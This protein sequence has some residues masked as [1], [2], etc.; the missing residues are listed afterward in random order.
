MLEGA[1]R[2]AAEH[3]CRVAHFWNLMWLN[4]KPLLQHNA[5]CL[6]GRGTTEK[7]AWLHAHAYGE[8]M[9]WRIPVGHPACRDWVNMRTEQLISYEAKR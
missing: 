7:K 9:A 4:C 6:R 3:R 5:Q 2:K 8:W 1:A